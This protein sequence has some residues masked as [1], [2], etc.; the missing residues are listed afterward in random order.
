M[1]YTLI[2]TGKGHCYK[3]LA[4]RSVS[5][6]MDKSEIKINYIL[7]QFRYKKELEF[8]S[9]CFPVC[10]HEVLLRNDVFN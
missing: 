4:Q 6:Q 8:A 1:F 10:N 2:S 9:S 3:C 7:L 5:M